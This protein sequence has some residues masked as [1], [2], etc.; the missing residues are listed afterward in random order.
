MSSWNLCYLIEKP[1]FHSL[2]ILVTFNGSF[3]DV[4]M[5]FTMWWKPTGTQDSPKGLTLPSMLEPLN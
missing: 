5:V 1:I 3:P 2:S 4:H